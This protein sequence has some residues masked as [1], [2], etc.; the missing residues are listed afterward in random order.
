MALTLKERK[1]AIAT[2]PWVA[3][4]GE[5]K[6]IGRC[7]L[8]RSETP[9]AYQN[10]VDLQRPANNE[11][12]EKYRCKNWARWVFISLTGEIKILCWAH[13]WYA[14]LRGNMAEEERYE[15]WAKQWDL[16]HWTPE[17]D[18]ADDPNVVVPQPE[19]PPR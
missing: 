13:L 10:A 14:G 12:N 15:Y 1:A 11:E 5:E 3:R 9:R 19:S 16:E 7:Q 4:S 6:P 2:M 17:L 18:P 8:M